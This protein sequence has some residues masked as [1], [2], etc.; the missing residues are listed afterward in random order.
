[1]DDFRTSIAF[2]PLIIAFIR[3]R[4]VYLNKML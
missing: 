4:F 3:A 2:L 1:M